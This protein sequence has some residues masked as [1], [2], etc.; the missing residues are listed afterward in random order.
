MFPSFRKY[1][2]F[3]WVLWRYFSCSEHGFPDFPHFSQYVS[4]LFVWPESYVVKRHHVKWN[5]FGDQKISWN[6][7]D[8]RLSTNV[9]MLNETQWHLVTTDDV[10]WYWSIFHDKTMCFIMTFHDISSII[11][12]CH[13]LFSRGLRTFSAQSPMPVRKILV[14]RWEQTI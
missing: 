10:W 14:Q 1:T 2:V 4:T 9:T 11:M 8:H 3:A 7:T 13:H 5:I 12:T 6:I